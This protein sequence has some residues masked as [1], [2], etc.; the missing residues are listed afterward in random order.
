MHVSFLI[1]YCLEQPGESMSEGSHR[2]FLVSKAESLIISYSYSGGAYLALGAH[3]ALCNK[4]SWHN[5][6]GFKQTC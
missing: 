3:F 1:R 6:L 4:V 5:A 2:V